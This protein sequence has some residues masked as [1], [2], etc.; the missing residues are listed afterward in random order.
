[1]HRTVWIDSSDP[2]WPREVAADHLAADADHD[3]EGVSAHN[4]DTPDVCGWCRLAVTSDG[5]RHGHDA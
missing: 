5:R 1:M 4:D 3:P 2:A